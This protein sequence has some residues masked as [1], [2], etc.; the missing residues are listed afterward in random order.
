MSRPVR[1][2]GVGG[3]DEALRKVRG[4]TVHNARTDDGMALELDGEG[5]QEGVALQGMDRRCGRLDDSE[6]GIKEGDAMNADK[7]AILSMVAAWCTA[8]IAAGGIIFVWQQIKQ[9]KISLQSGTNARLMAESLEILRFLADHPGNYDYFYHS[10]D[11]P[12]TQDESLKCATEMIA[13]YLEHVVF[14]EGYS[15]EGSSRDLV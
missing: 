4:A 10:K 7:I 6:F 5:F 15:P 1:R 8:V 3:G 13:N 9:V 14:A 2:F 11:P 12:E